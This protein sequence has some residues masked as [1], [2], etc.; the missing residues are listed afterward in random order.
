LIERHPD[1]LIVINKTD[2]P[3][4]WSVEQLRGAV[5]TVA[6]TGV[7]VPELMRRVRRHF[8]CDQVD[9]SRARCWTARQK[10]VLEAKLT[11]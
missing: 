3:A 10:A 11:E 5:A 7:G 4:R 1:A 2:V 8:G 6:T 9:V